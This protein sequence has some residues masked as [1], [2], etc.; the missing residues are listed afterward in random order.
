MGICLLVLSILVYRRL[1]NN[2][3]QVRNVLGFAMFPLILS[4]VLIAYY[5]GDFVH[6][7]RD[8]NEYRQFYLEYEHVLK[9]RV[10]SNE[11]RLRD[12]GKKGVAVESKMKIVNKNEE[13]IPV[14]LYLNPGLTVNGIK[15]G[16][17]NL[18]FEIR[19]TA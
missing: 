5:I 11:I 1:P 19:V 6:I 2:I 8:K 17:V 14:L 13:Q 3:H 18:S 9:N 10:L 12:L 15:N 16:S 7:E 4:I